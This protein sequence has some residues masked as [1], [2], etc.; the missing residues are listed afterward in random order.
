MSEKADRYLADYEAAQPLKTLADEHGLAIACL[1]HTRKAA[2]DDF[3]ETI[4]GTHGLAAAADTIIVAKR[5]RGQADAT[6]QVTGRD[7]EEQ[8][9][10]MRFAPEAGTWALL[11]DAQEWALSE[12]RRRILELLRGTEGMR[13][14]E[15]AETLDAPRDTIRQTLTRMAK[16]E[17]LE[18]DSGGTYRLPLSQVSQ[19]Q[20]DAVTGVTG[21][22]PPD[23]NP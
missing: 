10:A 7:M 21:V 16:D 14:K 5:A 1:H 11:G 9:L 20:M 8:E 18:V 12:T 17:Q 22:T 23:G 19:M 2:A 4:S 3:V 15:V 13:P 6:L